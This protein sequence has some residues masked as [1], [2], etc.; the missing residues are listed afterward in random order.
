M[1]S[2]HISKGAFNVRST[3]SA[4]SVTDFQILMFLKSRWIYISFC[5]SVHN[6]VIISNKACFLFF[7]LPILAPAMLCFT[8]DL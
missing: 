5:F 1:I 3:A 2:E 7:F 4:Y 6:L 8:L